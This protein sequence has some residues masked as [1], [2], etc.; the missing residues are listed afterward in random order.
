MGPAGQAAGVNLRQIREA[1]ALS[2][3]QL[4]ERLEAIGR[5]MDASAVNRIELGER[6]VDIDDLIALA[7]ALNVSP[8]RII[9]PSAEGSV[10]LTSTHA[11]SAAEAWAW[12]DGDKPL[13]VSASDPDGDTLRFRLDS[14]PAWARR[15]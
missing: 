9:F 4:S 5:P 2:L 7:M 15:N 13:T 12:A 11:V 10:E 1:R 14:R 8:I 6:R 3:R